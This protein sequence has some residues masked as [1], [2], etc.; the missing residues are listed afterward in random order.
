[1]PVTTAGALLPGTQFYTPGMSITGA[2]AGLSVDTSAGPA[3][4]KK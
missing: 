4:P 3:S 1:M 2:G